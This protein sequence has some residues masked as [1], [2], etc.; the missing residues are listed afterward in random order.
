MHRPERVSNAVLKEDKS[1]FVYLQKVAA[2]KV[3]VSLHE[4]IAKFLLLCLLLVFGVASERR[5][6]SNL[7]HQ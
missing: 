2:V 5:P 1:L 4:H 3:Q 6:F 7:G